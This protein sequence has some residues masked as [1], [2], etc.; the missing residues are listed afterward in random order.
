MAPASLIVLPAYPGRSAS[1]DSFVL[2]V[3]G[4]AR[5]LQATLGRCDVLTP[6]GLVSPEL[7]AHQASRPGSNPSLGGRAVRGLPAPARVALGDARAFV[8]ARKMRSQ[9]AI[10]NGRRYEFVVQKHRRFHDCGLRVARQRGV[11]FVLKIDALEVR[12]EASWGVRRPLWG[13]TVERM[14]EVRLI[15]QA[16]LVVPVSPTL[17]SQLASLGI[18]SEQRLVLDN[19]VDL[20]DFSPGPANDDLRAEHDLR[21]RLVVG[22]VGSFRP[23]HGL[24]LVPDIARMLQR[25]VPEAVL[26]LVGTGGL[27]DAISE[28]VDDLRDTV[29]LVGSVP[30][31]RIADW[32]RTFD[33]CLLLAN[34]GPYHYSPLKLYEYMGCGRPVVAAAVGGV[35]D[36]LHGDAGGILVPPGDANAVVNAVARLAADPSLRERIGA[37]ART[38]AERLGGWETRA[39][40]LIDALRDRSL[41]SQSFVAG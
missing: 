25:T 14:G 38:T 34:P 31:D 18:P 1:V 33:V 36:A 22:W 40:R 21:G 3:A 15:R 32:I 12:E 23:Y 10:L 17:D 5:G 16:D 35:A 27:F 9:A 19:G 7:V 11:P 24:S 41:L 37:E 6:S 20:D 4:L 29:R 26:C 39:E 2:D 30:H 13:G 8:R 28:S